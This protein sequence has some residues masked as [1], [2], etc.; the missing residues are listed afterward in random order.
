MHSPSSISYLSIYVSSEYLREQRSVRKSMLS[1][2]KDRLSIRFAAIACLFTSFSATGIEHEKVEETRIE[3]YSVDRIALATLFDYRRETYRFREFR[4][5][6]MQLDIAQALPQVYR[7]KL[8]MPR[9]CT[10]I[11]ALHPFQWIRAILVVPFPVISTVLSCYRI[12]TIVNS[13]MIV[14]EIEKGKA[15]SCHFVRI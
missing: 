8:R 14:F 6:S 9:F 3:C 11:D 7:C 13:A 4:I 12:S 10:L 5:I 15:I 1:G 2:G